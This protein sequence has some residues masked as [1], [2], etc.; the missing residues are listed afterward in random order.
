MRDLP[1]PD[2]K[3][4]RFRQNLRRDLRIQVS[5]GASNNY[6]WAFVAACFLT[7]MLASLVVIFIARPAIP[8]NLHAALANKP[9]TVDVPVE[10]GGTDSFHGIPA[11]GPPQGLVRLQDRYLPVEA[12]HRFLSNWYQNM[13]PTQ[14]FEI[15]AVEE[16]AIYAARRFKL[17]GGKT[18]V[19]YT[20]LSQPPAYL[21]NSY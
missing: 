16:E 8:K 9:A 3:V 11:S 7:G 1:L 14:P 12:D 17:S 10:R 21:E 4:D 2:I 19:V 5:A 6:K 13:Y 15:K 18:I 20:E